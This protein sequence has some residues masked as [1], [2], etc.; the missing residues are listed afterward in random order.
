MPPVTR[1]A[2]AAAGGGIDSIRF[3]LL[4]AQHAPTAHR[5]LQLVELHCAPFE[6]ALDDALLER[7]Y[8]FG[9]NTSHC[10]R[11]AARQTELSGEAEAAA[12]VSVTAAVGDEAKR[13]EAKVGEAKRGEAKGAASAASAAAAAAAA[14][15]S[16]VYIERLEIGA[17]ELTVSARTSRL[18]PM[19]VVASRAPLYLSPL[20]VAI[21][22][23]PAD[24]IRRALLSKYGT[25]A[26]SASPALVGSLGLLGN[27]T[28][29]LRS[30][31]VGLSD[32]LALPLAGARQ[33]P[34]QFVEGAV[35]GASSLLQHVSHG[36]LTSVSEFASAAAMALREEPR[37]EETTDWG[38]GG[39]D[40]DD[41]GEAL[42]GGAYDDDGGGGGGGG[43]G[44]RHGGGSSRTSTLAGVGKGLLGAVTK[45]VGGALELVSAASQTL[46]HSVGV[47][48]PA[49]PAPLPPSI[50][51]A[52]RPSAGWCIRALAPQQETLVCH[53]P[54][55]PML[56]S[57]HHE[58]AL[59][60][61]LLLSHAALYLLREQRVLI[62]LPLLCLERLEAPPPP[63]SHEGASTRRLLA[64][65]IAPEEAARLGLPSCMQ[66][67]VRAHVAEMFSVG[68]DT[69]AFN[70]ARM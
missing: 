69:V 45:P 42:E 51:L 13:G 34:R 47:V 4:A 14:A 65:F 43:G 11:R 35:A 70:T 21:L 66:F 1:A 6:V 57:E 64:V 17:L 61:E 54:A 59:A 12:R 55:L 49:R 62:A 60:H 30:M 40:D 18:G 29:L 41:G 8:A 52:R 2:T 27:P 46:I 36:A 22:S 38:G 44:G 28:A 5:Y 63:S 67:A 48:S 23:G 9:T 68:F 31:G 33:G 53:A 32:A 24:A 19:H 56:G 16:M 20:S 37:T 3:S 50:P 7:M 15:P 58:A 25:Q 10:M 39:D 26:L